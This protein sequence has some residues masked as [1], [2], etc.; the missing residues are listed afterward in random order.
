MI[1]RITPTPQLA[2]CHELVNCGNI[3][4]SAYFVPVKESE[5]S[6]LSSVVFLLASDSGTSCNRDSYISRVPYYRSL[7]RLPI[8]LPDPMLTLAFSRL[9]SQ[10][11]S[12]NVFDL[13]IV[14]RLFLQ[15]LVPLFEFRPLD[16]FPHCHMHSRMD[17]IINT[18][19]SSG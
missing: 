9:H 16:R 10:K 19:K 2:L 7:S 18:L 8:A 11:S 5:S 15:K 17:T 6:A 4:A 1:D 13:N 3:Y 14:G 12:Y